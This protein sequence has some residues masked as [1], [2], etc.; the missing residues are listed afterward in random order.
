MAP[1]VPAAPARKP[2]ITE[3]VIEARLCKKP[4][5]PPASVRERQEGRVTLM[6]LVGVDGK[7]LDSY[8]QKSSGHPALDAAARAA[9]SLCQFKPGTVD[10]VAQQ[11]WTDLEYNWRLY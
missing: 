4:E 1:P 3:A 6:L 7:V 10:G 11:S 9:L 2:V 5:Y 8:V